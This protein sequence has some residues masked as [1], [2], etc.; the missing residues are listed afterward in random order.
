[1]EPQAVKTVIVQGKATILNGV[2]LTVDEEK[3]KE[4]V[5][6]TMKRLG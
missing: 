6:V 2:L 1:M 4:K 5:R 3:I